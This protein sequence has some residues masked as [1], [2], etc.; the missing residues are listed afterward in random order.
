[1]ENLEKVLNELKNNDSR[2]GS[3]SI[4]EDSYHIIGI[5]EKIISNGNLKELEN[6]NKFEIFKYVIEKLNKDYLS[7]YKIDKD[8]YNIITLGLNDTVLTNISDISLTNK[9]EITVW[10][11]NKNYVISIKERN[12]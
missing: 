5:D 8:I 1:M 11:K 9:N 4:T 2:V 10:T 3:Y 12:D 6:L 7:S